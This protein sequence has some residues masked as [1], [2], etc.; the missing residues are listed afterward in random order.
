LQGQIDSPPGPSQGSGEIQLE[1]GNDEDFARDVANRAKNAAVIDSGKGLTKLLEEIQK[2]PLPPPLPVPTKTVSNPKPTEPLPDLPAPEDSK[3]LQGA[4]DVE[5]PKIAVEIRASE[6]QVSRARVAEYFW[7]LIG[8]YLPR[9][10]A[11]L[12]D[13]VSPPPANVTDLDA[14][15][16]QTAQNKPAPGEPHPSHSAPAARTPAADGEPVELFT[17][18][19]T[20]DV[21]DL[22]VPTPYIPIAMSR[23]Y[24]SGR[25]YHGPFGFGW[26]HPYDVYLRELNDGGFALWTG[27]LQEQRF[28]NTGGV[29][30]PQ[31]GFAAR[32]ERISGATDVFVV[33]FPGGLVWQ[34][35]RPIGWSDAERIPLTRISDRHGNTVDL[36]Y[37]P[38]N[39]VISVLDAGGRGL[40]FHYGNCEL[41][42]RVTDHTGLRQVLYQHDSDVEHLVRVVLPA[43]AQYPKGLA[44]KYEYDSHA[45][46]PAMQHNILRI[47]DAEDRLML[48]NEFAGPEAG[49]EFNALV[50]QQ[51]AEFEYQFEYQQIQ[52]VWPDP[53]YVEVLAARTLVRPP[54][55]SLH[56]YT[57]N[58][59]GDLLDYRCRLGRDRSFRVVSSQWKHDVEGNV[60][61]TVGPDGLRTVFTYDFKN[62][63]PC[64]RRNLLRVELAA[65]LSEILPS[66]VVY[67]GQY[68]PRF[69]LATRSIDEIGAET[70]F[71][72]DFDVNPAGATGRLARIQLPAVV[73]VDGV[74][75][76]SILQFEHNAHGQLTATIKAEGGRTELTYIS[77]GVRDGFL[78]QVTQEP[79]TARLVSKFEYDGAGFVNQIH[80]P[81]SRTIGLTP[82]A[83]GQIEQLVLPEVGGQTGQVRKWF[84]DSGE[85]VRVERP[86]GSVAALIQSTSIID[87]Y[88]RD[89]LGNVRSMTL[90]A[91][92][93]SRRQLLQRVDHEGRAVS[94]WDPSG[95]RSDRVFGENGALLSE[96]AAVGDSTALTTKY[97]HDRAGRV[98]RITAPTA[99]VTKI[100]YDVWGRPH[101]ITLPSGAVKAL[102]FGADDR[103]LAEQ[104]EERGPAENVPGPLLQRQTYEH[105]KRGRLIST[106]LSSFRDDPDTAVPLT[107]RFLYDKDDN[108]RTVLL[109]RGAEYRYDFDKTGRLIETT[110]SHGNV[111][112]LFYDSSGDLSELTR[113]EVENGIT[114][115]ATRSN[116]YDARGRLKHSEFLGSFAE[117]QYDDRNLPIEQRAPSEVT[118][119]SQF[120]ALGQVI[121]SVIDPGGAA[122][123]SQF[124]YDLNGR[125][126]RFTDPT[127]QSTKWERDALGRAVAIKPPDGTTW[128]YLF[129][130]KARKIEQRMPSGT[131]V[132]IEFA[133]SQDRTGKIVSSGLPGQ[134]AV[135]PH[136]LAYDGI[137]RLLSAS[138]GLDSVVRRYDSLGRLIE[139]T[140]R[141]KTVRMEFDDTIGSVDLV[142]PDGRRERTEHNAAGQPTRVVLVTPG[143]LGGTAGDV[144]LQIIYSSAGRPARM[145]YGN[146]V[147]G[148]LVHD[149]QG[150]VIRIEYQ[151]AG[152]VLDSCRLRYDEGGHRALVQ[153]LGAPTRN[154][155]HTFDGK[156]R[157]VEA[158]SGFPLAPLPDVTAPAG[159]VADVAAARIAA[160]KAPG[161]AFTL[162]DA[163]TRTK[164]TGLNGGAPNETYLSGPDH[165]LTAVGANTIFYN[166]DGHRTGDA[167]YEYDLDAL[168]RVRRVRDR[169]TKATLAE[170]RYDALSRVATGTTDG[171]EFER[172]FVGSTQIQEVSGAAGEIARQH[173]SHPLWPSPFCVVDAKGHAY[174]HQDE[175]W[176][177]MCV[178]DAIGAVL[179]RHRYDVFGA[180]T[181]FGA[182]GVTP[183]ASLR[184]EPTWR[185]LPALGT[186]R[187]LSTPRRLYDPEA[188]V[189]TSRDPLLYADSPS[190]YSYAAHN[191]VDFADPTG[192]DKSPL[193]EKGH[194]IA[195][196]PPVSNVPNDTLYL[197]PGFWQLYQNAKQEEQR[198]NPDL[199]RVYEGKIAAPFAY[200]E[201]YLVRPILNI[202]HSAVNKAITAGEHIGRGRLWAE[203]GESAEAWAERLEA[204]ADLSLAFLDITS[205]LEGFL[206]NGGPRAGNPPGLSTAEEKSLIRAATES[207]SYAPLNADASGGTR[208][209]IVGED[210]SSTYAVRINGNRITYDTLA[211]GKQGAVR[212]H[213]EV[214]MN[215]LGEGKANWWNGPRGT[216]KADWWT[217]TH[218][219]AEG[220]FGGKY[221]EYTFIKQ[222][223]NYG[224]FYGYNVKNVYNQS[225]ASVLA[226]PERPT[227]YSWCYSSS[228]F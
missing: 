158:R 70:R 66:R 140:A 14:L 157:L 160:A 3:D 207:E 113:I 51:L 9:S 85:I 18:A 228:C 134:E 59:R 111:Q 172:W 23:S 63:D 72:Y 227:V 7:S 200:L 99:D 177:T 191:P 173:S 190:P 119:R 110:D 26:D 28:R 8:P 116:V 165:R 188:G 137:G 208:L 104:V 42:E 178:T 175:G 73:G 33:H 195:P 213:M 206:G 211:P 108:V 186:T 203:Q 156:E 130:T 92:T 179:E 193:A 39:Q 95:V 194:S 74:P 182:D 97:A 128:Q 86:A 5:A 12:V 94:M 144:L 201:E 180:S 152:V 32:F 143:D 184:T 84:D 13:R 226:P 48:E 17:G 80:G 145:I 46:H 151:K 159:H 147:E 87:D 36:S 98:V 67:Q 216:P 1:L 136:E 199:H 117:F 52:Y 139:E 65:P 164:V 56:T 224:R 91:N 57:F 167:R 71:F 185:G 81:G 161:I 58:Y 176:S 166:A 124:E 21:V 19:F 77:G 153:Y 196:P 114:R 50:R 78:S 47:R 118:I 133:Q 222:E 4:A 205:V 122:L 10:V 168:N 31:P 210:V 170:L 105:D 215:N 49:W 169:A 209:W 221:L 25:P 120:D 171:E 192:L 29:F 187:L 37:G 154:L 43:T 214:L 96:T 60:T 142:F 22:I 54:D 141:G 138:T 127:G 125:L 103:L 15:K 146:G 83:N 40:H 38:I 109:P 150:R 44:T 64:A 68:E 45:D 225:R 76:Q 30:E 82:N 174:I 131:Q 202:P 93:E 107:T 90:A 41:L 79:G 27:H 61:E 6:T 223:R 35:E 69:Q 16:Q 100:E 220:A 121:E 20:I 212:A 189:F 2:R 129:D 115:T 53:E 55:G 198:P 75:Q 106:T 162:D 135:A 219:N 24:R 62:A 101:R 102:E 112:R 181:T 148:Q 197:R 126:H 217:G 204:V 89:A 123:R 149:D 11:E 34:F 88:E 218:G 132:V 155:L 163:D 183:L